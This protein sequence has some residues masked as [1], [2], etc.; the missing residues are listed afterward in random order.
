MVFRFV[1]MRE[2]CLAIPAPRVIG[3]VE[4]REAAQRQISAQNRFAFAAIPATKLLETST[5]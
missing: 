2:S 3:E 1:A 4:A 5:W